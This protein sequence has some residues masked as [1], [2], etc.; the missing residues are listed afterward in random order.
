MT[1]LELCEP[2]FQYLCQLNR[3]TRAGAEPDYA[4]VRN[5]IKEL[6]LTELP[7]A[8][9]NDHQLRQLYNGPVQDALVYLADYLITSGTYSFKGQWEANRL[10]AE[11]RKNAGDDAFFD[12]VDVDLKTHSADGIERLSI[13]YVCLALGFAGRYQE[14]E[15]DLAKYMKD[16]AAQ[17]GDKHLRAEKQLCPQAYQGIDQSNL[18]KRPARVVLF[19]VVLLIGGVLSLFIAN[20]ALFR[21]ASDDLNDALTVINKHPITAVTSA[22]PTSTSA[23]TTSGGR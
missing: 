20:V 11:L 10:A 7:N 4:K 3:S 5:R 19:I 1:L 17:I 9:G 21:W 6:L 16:I 14:H 18:T 23:V 8:A 12:L 2:Y 15:A 22:A 13:Y